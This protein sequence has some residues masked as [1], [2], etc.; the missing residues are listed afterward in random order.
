MFTTTGC[1]RNPTKIPL[2]SSTDT[3][4]NE[5]SA[6]SSIGSPSAAKAGRFGSA[7]AV[8]PTQAPTKTAAAIAISLRG[9]NCGWLGDDSAT[10]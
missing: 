8:Q 6:G 5:P 3:A 9:A 7:S 1:P 2:N 4:G 10:A